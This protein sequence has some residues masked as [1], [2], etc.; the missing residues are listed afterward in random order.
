MKYI[1]NIKASSHQ[2]QY[3]ARYGIPWADT[4][5]ACDLRSHTAS[6]DMLCYAIQLFFQEEQCSDE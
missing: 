6:N 3:Y 4:G 5:D 1:A 2:V